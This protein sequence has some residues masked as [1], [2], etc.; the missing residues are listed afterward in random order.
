M[1]IVIGY[2][3]KD[4]QRLTIVADQISI[5]Q[6]AVDGEVIDARVGD[7][8][9]ASFACQDVKEVFAVEGRDMTDITGSW[10]D[11][12]SRNTFCAD[13]VLTATAS[14]HQTSVK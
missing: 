10:R 6:N 9:M 11:L 7:T 13:G 2:A 14:K 5:K 8:V 12:I 4:G 1:K 3:A